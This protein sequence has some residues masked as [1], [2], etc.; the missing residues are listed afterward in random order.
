MKANLIGLAFSRA[1]TAQPKNDNHF[2]TK[3]DRV[4]LVAC[5]PVRSL[6]FPL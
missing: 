6:Q 4:I 1:E 5:S 2:E 3:L